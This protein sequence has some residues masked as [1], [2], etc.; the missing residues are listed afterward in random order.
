MLRLVIFEFPYTGPWGDDMT[1]STRGL[2]E[3]IATEDGLVWKVW[4]EN[5]ERGTAGGAYLFTNPESAQRYIDKH[6]ARL[7]KL[8]ITNVDTRVFD[9]NADLTAITLGTNPVLPAAVTA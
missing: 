1:T 9:V 4:I 3:D 7:P 5:K 6:S 2:A 8:G